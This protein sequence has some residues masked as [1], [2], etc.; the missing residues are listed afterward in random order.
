MFIFLKLYLIY[1]DLKTQ[2][3]CDSDLLVNL[4]E[5]KPWIFDFDRKDHSNRVVQDK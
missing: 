3:S 2:W 4:T 1:I 5:D